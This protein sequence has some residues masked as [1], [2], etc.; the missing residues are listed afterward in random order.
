MAVV[1]DLQSGFDR[2]QLLDA[3]M[4]QELENPDAFREE[5]KSISV[6]GDRRILIQRSVMGIGLYELL[7]E[8][9]RG[10]PVV[11]AAVVFRPSDRLRRYLRRSTAFPFT[12]SLRLMA[13]QPFTMALFVAPQLQVQ[14]GLRDFLSFSDG[15]TR[16]MS[17]MSDESRLRP[18]AR[19]ELGAQPDFDG[20]QI[21]FTDSA[22][23]RNAPESGM[24]LVTRKLGET[25]SASR[26]ELRAVIQPLR[27]RIIAAMPVAQLVDGRAR[28]VGD[29][30]DE[31]RER[32]LVLYR[33]MPSSYPGLNSERAFLAAPATVTVEL[34]LAFPLPSQG[35][36]AF[37]YRGPFRASD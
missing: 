3:L 15:A 32:A 8:E 13:D 21:I 6:D 35:Q 36:A 4:A 14:G 22:D 24:Q 1:T 9:L 10:L 33:S 7:A 37:V 28:T 20:Y 17:V 12:S 5:W 23:T 34:V 25:M 30:P 11:D 18:L 26:H 31:L 27:E 19:G 2:R 16:A 29:L